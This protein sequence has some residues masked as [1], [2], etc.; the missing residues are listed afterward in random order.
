MI[1]YPLDGSQGRDKGQSMTNNTYQRHMGLFSS[2]MLIAGSMIGSGV[3]IVAADMVRIGHTGTSLLLGW[4][5]TGIIT[6][7][8]AL[9]FGELAG[10]FPRAGGQYSYIKEI[11]GPMTAFTF[12]W[13]FF[14]VI[15]CGTIAAV[16]VGFGKYL[17][18]FFP[19]ISDTVWLGSK[20]HI[21]Q[22]TLLNIKDQFIITLGPYEM[23]LTPSRLSGI[24]IIGLLTAIN[25]LGVKA[26]SW[27]QNIL[28]VIKIAS[29]AVLIFFGLYLSP[30]TVPDASPLPFTQDSVYYGF[31][32]SLLIMQTGSLFSATA[33]ESLTF[34]ASEVKDPKRVIPLSLF[35][36]TTLVCGIYFIV[37]LIYIKFLGPVGIATAPNDRV[38]SLALQAMMGSSGAYLMAGGILIS[39]FGCVNGIVLSGARVYQSMAE[40]GL[41]FKGVKALN[42]NGVPAYGLAYQ[43]IWRCIL[44][45]TGTY[46]QLLDFVMFAAILFFFLTVLGVIILRI[47][48]PDLDRPI[49]VIAYPLTPL[50]YLFLAGSVMIALLIFRPSYTWPGLMIVL[51]GIPIYFLRPKKEQI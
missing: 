8:C 7:L 15:E 26:G 34:V 25:L 4:L 10:M 28:T 42:S 18:T 2:V 51:M 11:Y 37:N 24:A 3:F 1:Y 31:L 39:M 46:G 17:G 48:K 27:I 21:D 35:I 41:F 9:S 45:L 29:L 20:I 22:F 14:T 23:G 38:G 47:R 12:G 5:L 32:V 50:L 6:I 40:D 13:T 43:A 33:W 44:T 30:Q 19:G 36:G 16:A 49:K